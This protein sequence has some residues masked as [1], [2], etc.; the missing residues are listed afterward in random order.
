MLHSNGHS[1]LCNR[2]T[3]NI[4]AAPFYPDPTGVYADLDMYS[5]RPL[6]DLIDNHTLIL[7]HEVG[8]LLP[9]PTTG[10]HYNDA[11]H[12]LSFR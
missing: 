10:Q 11:A 7:G 2:C 4:V 1:V 9:N 5:E 8:Y 12:F 3:H 6:D